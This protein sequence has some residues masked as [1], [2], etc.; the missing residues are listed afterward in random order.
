MWSSLAR[1]ATSSSTP[2]RG[3]TIPEDPLKLFTRSWESLQVRP[4][5]FTVSEPREKLTRRLTP[6]S[7]ELRSTST[8]PR[9]PHPPTTRPTPLPHRLRTLLR[10]RTSRP[11]PRVPAEE[12]RP[13]DSR[14]ALECT[15][16]GGVGERR[17]RS[18]V[19]R[20]SGTTRREFPH[21]WS[22]QQAFVSYCYF[23]IGQFKRASDGCGS[24]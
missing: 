4:Q 1:L 23:H 19:W 15:E 16:S 22:C 11:L 8:P 14:Q 10:E 7:V 5:F 13:R 21:P 24:A 18:V 12:R 20:C 9:E 2:S 17:G 6:G 3:K